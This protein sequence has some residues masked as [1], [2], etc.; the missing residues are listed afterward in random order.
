MAEVCAYRSKCNGRDCDKDFCMKKYRLDCLFD[1]S[2]LTPTQRKPRTLCIDRDGTDREEFKFLAS[3]EANIEQ[4]V[5]DG[6]NLYLYSYGCG[7]GK[8]SW[9]IRLLSSYFGKIWHKSTFE[10]QGLF[11]NVPKYLLALKENISG[12]SDYAEAINAT[13]KTADFVIWDDIAAKVGS[14]F[15]L[16]HLLS[17]INHRIDAGKCNIFTSNLGP[18]EIGNALGERLASR[19]CNKSYNIELKGSDKRALGLNN[20]G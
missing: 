10:C 2:L 8:T 16:N 6:L 18:R 12:H 11:I 4:F 5:A 17:L 15:E 1:K 19:I 9:A 13:V 3:I 14:E 20:G 7:N